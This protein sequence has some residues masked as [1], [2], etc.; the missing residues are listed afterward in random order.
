MT[1]KNKYEN[2]RF[3]FNVFLQISEISWNILQRNGR[4]GKML[5][6]LEM[7]G[8]KLTALEFIVRGFRGLALPPSPLAC[9]DDWEYLKPEARVQKLRLRWK[10]SPEGSGFPFK[11][12]TGR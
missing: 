11:T 1:V 4:Y 5:E 3:L 2:F 8:F 6:N 9:K 10:D 7:S 12:P